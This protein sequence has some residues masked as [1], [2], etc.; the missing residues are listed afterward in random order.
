MLQCSVAHSMSVAIVDGLKI[1]HVEHVEGY[2]KL[3]LTC[4][5]K[6]SRDYF[7][8]IPTVEYLR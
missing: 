8:Q 6:I 1:V 7:F 4:L 3:F 2:C 5:G